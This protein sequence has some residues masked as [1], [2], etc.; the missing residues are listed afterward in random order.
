MDRV[1]VMHLIDTLDAG[2]LERVAVNLAN[3]LP[4]DRYRPYL[5][6]SRREGVLGGEVEADVGRLA[7]GRSSRFDLRAIRRL[8]RFIRAQEIRILHAHGTALLVA[9]MASLFPPH[10]AVV[11]HDHYGRQGIEERPAW[12]YRLLAIPVDA[13]IAVNRPLADWSRFRLR[14]R[15]D[16]VWYIPNFVREAPPGEGAPDL[17][18]EPGSRIV[19]VANFRPQK[20][21]PTLLRAMESVVRRTPAAHLLLIGAAGDPAYLGAVEREIGTRGLARNVSILGQR[22]DVPDVLRACDVG[23]LSSASEG[24]P[25]ALIEYG[26]ARL[27]VVSTRVGQCPEVLEEGEAGL[28]VPP[29]EPD[30]LA[31]A[32]LDLLGSP[33]RRAALASRFQSRTRAAHGAGPI[34]DQVVG[35]YDAVTGSSLL[36]SKA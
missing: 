8:V 9:G 5:C 31:E 3:L 4:R 19:C 11:W 33:S 25:L 12:I 26:M 22:M 16:R 30:R 20:D 15:A 10:P 32:L 1:G 27:P 24:L 29:G 23:V 21:H 34:L 35:V 36:H 2:G 28:L 17:P 7:L 13:V 18:G 14:F 6:T